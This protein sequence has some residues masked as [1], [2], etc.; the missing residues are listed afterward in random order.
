MAKSKPQSQ[1]EPKAGYKC[2]VDRTKFA[3]SA[4]PIMVKAAVPQ[5]PNDD[6]TT[7][8]PVPVVVAPKEF[9]SGSLGWFATQKIVVMIDGVPCKAGI[10]VQIVLDHSKPEGE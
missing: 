8:P 1:S 7:A 6:G 3:Q 9:S 4:K 10:Q 2:P 5:E